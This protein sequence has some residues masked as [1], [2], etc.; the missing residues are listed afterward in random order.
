MRALIVGGHH[1]GQ[2]TDSVPGEFMQKPVRIMTC[3]ADFDPNE[4]EQRTVAIAT[5]KR[6]LW[7]SGET[8]RWTIWAPPELSDIDVMN[9]LLRG[10]HPIPQVTEEHR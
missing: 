5:Y 1:D 7:R 3:V 4:P 8:Q 10:Y 6:R 2:W 9:K